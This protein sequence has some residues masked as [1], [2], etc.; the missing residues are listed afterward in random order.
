MTIFTAISPITISYNNFTVIS[1]CSSH[2]AR[3]QHYDL[4]WKV[5]KSSMQDFSYAVWNLYI[6]PISFV[7][8]KQSHFTQHL[9][10]Q[11]RPQGYKSFSIELSMQFILLINVKMPTCVGILTFISM[12]NTTSERLQ[13]INFFIC[14]YLSFYEQIN[15]V[16]S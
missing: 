4:T 2:H 14:Q 15:F 3:N 11:T 8:E 7:S 9:V 12:I 6:H 5:K 13:A 10:Y 16:L 1:D